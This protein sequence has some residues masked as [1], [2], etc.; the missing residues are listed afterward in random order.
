M[1]RITKFIHSCLLVE[2]PEIIALIDPGSFTYE[3]H[4]L[5]LREVENLDYIIITHEHADHYHE[6]FLRQISQKFPHTP[7]VSNEDLAKK[8]KQLKL[9]N[10]LQVGS[11][12][13]LTVFEA[14]H[15]PLPLNM[16][17]VTNI[18]VHVANK[19]TH[20]GDSFDFKASCEILAMPLT[21][22][23][24]SLREALE[25]VVKLKPKVVTPVHDWEWHKAAREARYKMCREL[26]ELH[27]IEFIALENAQP[28]EL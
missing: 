18:G 7:I 12:D 10:P 28:V 1:I 9:A 26:L 3:S 21:G 22:P 16:P 19:L 4:L 2:T 5:N 15:E 27:G 8:I 24:G 13:N 11:S 25:K 17:N 23:W 20:P 14:A 6:A